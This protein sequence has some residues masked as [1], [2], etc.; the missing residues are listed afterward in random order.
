MLVYLTIEDL[1]EIAVEVAGADM[2]DP[3]GRRHRWLGL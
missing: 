1:F 2:V 3:A